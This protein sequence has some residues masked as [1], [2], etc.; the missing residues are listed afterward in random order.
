M[1]YL[2]VV[3][4]M[5]REVQNQSLLERSNFVLLGWC[6]RSSGKFNNQKHN[7]GCKSCSRDR[8]ALLLQEKQKILFF[9]KDFELPLQLC[10]P[11]RI[12]S[13]VELFIMNALYKEFT[14][15]CFIKNPPYPF[16]F[17]IPITLGLRAS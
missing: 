6:C 12:A 7:V 5:M 15:I 2:R 11:S 3:R 4:K 10:M 1:K 13:K 14:I 17:C 8:E 9:L 16:K